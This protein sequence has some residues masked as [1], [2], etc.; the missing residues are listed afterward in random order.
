M[1]VQDVSGVMKRIQS[2]IR[3]L[4][5]SLEIFIKQIGWKIDTI[6]AIDIICER[7]AVAV[8][9]DFI[10][11]KND[12]ST[13]QTW[14]AV[15]YEFWEE[16]SMDY[17]AKER[18]RQQRPIDL[19]EIK[20]SNFVRD[21]TFVLSKSIKHVVR[22][23]SLKMDIGEERK[24]FSQREADIQVWEEL[25][26]RISDSNHLASLV[27][28][29]VNAHRVAKVQ[30]IEQCKVGPIYVGD[31]TTIAYTRPRVSRLCVDGTHPDPA[32]RTAL[33]D[34]FVFSTTFLALSALVGD[35]IL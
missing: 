18:R 22:K 11:E 32:M 10:L 26:H 3:E 24:R 2:H 5:A 7:F 20:R 15:L 8:C 9:S 17:Y 13:S 28:K 25:A 6:N 33:P 31:D 16:L 4:C 29:Y 34:G 1:G 19:A 12:S 27:G 35:S 14:D 30:P 23:K 21:L